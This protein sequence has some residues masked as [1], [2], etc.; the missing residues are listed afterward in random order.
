MEPKIGKR[1]YRGLLKRAANAWT[2]DQIRDFAVQQ[3]V[4][5][6]MEAAERGLARL[7]AAQA[8]LTPEVAQ[9]VIAS[10]N[11]PPAKIED[12]Q[13]LHALVVALE[14]EVELAQMQN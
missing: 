14:K 11:M 4:L 10:L 7:Q 1:M 9:K 13:S 12:L 3:R 2:P 8:R 5:A 6:Q